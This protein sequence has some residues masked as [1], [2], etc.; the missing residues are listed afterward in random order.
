[1]PFVMYL[2]TKL[3]LLLQHVQL[4]LGWSAIKED[5]KEN[6][7]VFDTG[8]P[9]AQQVLTWPGGESQESLIEYLKF[10]VKNELQK[11]LSSEA[12]IMLQGEEDFET[13]D[14]RYTNYKRPWY[15]AGVSVAEESDVIATVGLFL[16]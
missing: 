16:F 2:I 3:T 12:R 14:A 13:L 5:V 7:S 6:T 8:L 11:R 15:I 9:A 10:S 1:M 4:L